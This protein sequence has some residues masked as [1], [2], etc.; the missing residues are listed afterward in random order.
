MNSSKAPRP[1]YPGSEPTSADSAKRQNRDIRLGFGLLVLALL[2]GSGLM[3]PM[4]TSGPITI[5]EHGS[6][7][8]IDSDI[9]STS[10]QRSLDYAAIPPLSGWLQQASLALFGKSEW[11][12]RLP[13]GLCYLA[14]IAITYCVGRRL[15][16]PV[17]GGIAALVIAWHPEAMDEVRIARCYGLLLMLSAALLWITVWWRESPKSLTRALCWSLCS[18]AA[19][20]THVFAAPLIMLTGASLILTIPWMKPEQRPSL[21]G[22]VVACIVLGL[23]ALPLVPFVERLWQWS[24]FLE[25]IHGSVSVWRVIGPL[26]WLSLPVACGLAWLTPARRFVPALR[27]S[28]Y[29]ERWLLV[30]W[31]LVPHA[32]LALFYSTGPGTQANTRYRV[33]YAAGGA[34]L[35]AALLPVRSR[36]WG[37]VAGTVAALALTW[38]VCERPPW[39]PSRLNGPSDDDWYQMSLTIQQ[40]GSKG[41]PIF[42]QSGLAEG[43]L[44]PAFSDQPLFL[45]YVGC[46]ISRFYVETPHPRYGLPFSWSGQSDVRKAFEQFV[47]SAKVANAESI[48]VAAAI[49][50]DLNRQSLA[51][52]DD[53]L[54]QTGFARVK[55]WPYRTAVLQR[56]QPRAPGNSTP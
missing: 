48:W 23:G 45:E 7:W 2:S 16:G 56:F 32:A 50:T 3:L 34:C 49:D 17:V 51:G 39:Q 20:W 31:T 6:Y 42:V 33:P 36:P 53:I 27:A 40:S 19:L 1:A 12:F 46:R 5:D 54:Q 37:S 13:S 25:Y 47:T 9:P 15:G 4:M 14:G 44:V 24:P 21:L 43:S 26:W 29:T 22:V 52:I 11:A 8:I 35:L 30:V 10:L 55:E 28:F 38:A 41:E 18:V